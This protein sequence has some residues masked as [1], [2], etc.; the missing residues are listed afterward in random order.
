V[1]VVTIAYAAL[2]LFFWAIPATPEETETA[3]LFLLGSWVTLLG[4][5]LTLWRGL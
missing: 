4:L 5:R 1:I 2:A 3:L